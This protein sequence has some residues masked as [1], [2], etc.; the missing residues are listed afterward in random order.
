MLE[1]ALALAAL[2]QPLGLGEVVDPERCHVAV[3]AAREERAGPRIGEELVGDPFG[4]ADVDRLDP[5]A[6]RLPHR[7]QER[8]PVAEAR[9]LRFALAEQGLEDVLVHER[10]RRAAR[11]DESPARVEEHELRDPELRRERH[12]VLREVALLP[13]AK[14]EED[15]EPLVPRHAPERRPHRVGRRVGRESKHGSRRPAFPSPSRSV[16][17]RQESPLARLPHRRPPHQGPRFVPRQVGDRPG[18]WAKIRAV[19]RGRGGHGDQHGPPTELF[20][21]E[22]LLDER[23]NGRAEAHGAR[24]A[25][26]P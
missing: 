6:D 21:V 25:P 4:G 2:E 26:G 17:C 10:E 7:H 8:S 13:G 19:G 1:Q 9:P 22:I 14:G 24:H 12:R 15:A 3:V 5:V 23:F 18:E 16:E 11:R 20:E